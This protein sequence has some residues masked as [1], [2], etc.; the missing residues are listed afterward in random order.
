MIHVLENEKMRKKVA[1][2]KEDERKLGRIK[3]TSKLKESS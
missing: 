2:R 1:Q 3:H